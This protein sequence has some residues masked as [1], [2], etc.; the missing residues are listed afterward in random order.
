MLY[1]KWTKMK[2]EYH[3]SEKDFFSPLCVFLVFS[4]KELWINKSN[5]KYSEQEYRHKVTG[6]LFVTIPI[7]DFKRRIFMGR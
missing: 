4:S 7:T 3:Y 5:V 6:N 1:L 2:N